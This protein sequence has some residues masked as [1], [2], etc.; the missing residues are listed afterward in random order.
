MHTNAHTHKRTY[1][2]I[3]T[4]THIYTNLDV[5]AFL[6]T[7][8]HYFSSSLSI[9]VSFFLIYAHTHINTQ[10]EKNSSYSTLQ[11][12]SQPK[13]IHDS[14]PQHTNMHTCTQT[15][16]CTNL[17][18]HAYTFTH[19]YTQI[20]S[21][22]FTLSLAIF[23]SHLHA[24]A[25]NFTARKFVHLSHASKRNH[26]RN[27]WMIPCHWGVWKTLTHLCTCLVAT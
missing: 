8:I 13:W 27:T 2:R 25:N 4:H 21:L 24:H 17:N 22:A 18:V 12:A 5:H 26:W 9:S 14:S 7:H 16:T 6:N 15:H 19:L 1:M 11:K 3:H 20:L 23:L 10:P